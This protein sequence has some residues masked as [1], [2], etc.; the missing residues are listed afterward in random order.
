M[1]A[2][3]P[4]WRIKINGVAYTSTT[5]ADLTIQSG[6][7]NI[8]EQAYAGYCTLNLINYSDTVVPISINDAVT[9]E[10]QDNAAAYVALFGGTVVDLG[11][12]IRDIGNTYTQTVTVTAVGALARLPK[13]L[14]NGVLSEALDG[15][16]IAVILQDLLLN[17]W[18]EVAAATTWATYEAGVSWA[19]AENVGLGEIDSGN[20][21]LAARTSDVTDMYSICAALANSGLG[22]LF[23]DPQGRISYADST[24][25]STYLATYGYTELTANDALGAGL[26]IQ[27]RAGDVRN[28]L[29]IKY[30]A[31]SSSEVSDEDATSI[32]QYGRLAQMITTTLADSGDAVDQAAFYLQIRANPSANLEQITYELTN[33]EITSDDRDSLLNIFMGLPVII[34]DLPN[35]MGATFLGFVEG[36]QFR[37]AFNQLA[38]TAT[39]SPLAYSLQ[40]MRWQDV[41]VSEAWNTVSGS[42]EWQDALVVN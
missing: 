27:T 11:I 16:Q 26:K 2:W 10:V 19:D 34:S 28:D 15:E 31:T 1:S 41:S 21:A 42:L 25:R 6:R 38:I 39:L 3:N 12:A 23:E 37:A 17:S 8:Y 30:G 24:H 32:A 5:L 13:A 29:T 35:N 40:A 4:V 20:Y 14:T 7:T 9:I 22:Y 33:S 36:W 18:S